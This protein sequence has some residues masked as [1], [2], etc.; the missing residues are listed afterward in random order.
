MPWFERPL[1]AVLR[2]EYAAAMRFAED[3]AAEV[4]PAAPAAP[5][6]LYVHVPFC[7]VLCP[8]C[9]FH[10]VRHNESKTKWYFDALRREI[11]LYH[12]AGFR[13]A[14]VYVGGGTPTVDAD[15]L[16]ETL[17][18]VRA[19]SPVRAISIETNPNHL[20]A[21][22]LQR[23]RAAGVT[24]LSV[25]VQSFDDGLLA[26]MVRLEKYGNAAQIRERLA[27][28]QGIFPTLN[29]D[30]I[31][32][33]P[34]QTMAMLDHDLAELQALAVDQVSFYPLMTAPSA[35]HAMQKSMGLSDQGLR[36]AMYERI[37]NHLL[38]S[39]RPA[40]AWCFSRN[41]GMFDEYIIDQDDYVGVGSG[42]F[43]YV[44]GAMYSTTFSLKHYCRRVEGGR[45][46][47]TQRRKL[48]LKERMR[49]DFLVRLFGGQLRHDYVEKRYGRA[50]AVRM[51][52]ELAAMRLIGAT[53]HDADAIRLTP[54]GMY[55]WVL[56][57][58]EFFNSVNGVREQ[59]REHVRTELDAWNEE[60][61]VPVASIGRLPQ[62]AKS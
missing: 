37:L 30:M 34:G 8:F 4:M 38:P 50:F 10:R 42:A 2:H 43:S 16:I 55:C 31:F 14:D 9:S 5:C 57:M 46:G 40:S 56:M 36:H 6:Q 47:I 12:E 39:Y 15:E 25:G 49:Y 52:P 26:S 21:Q 51:A 48:G 7:E 22:T 28:A 24:R 1:L 29:V 33:L 35:R 17:E 11:R 61:S 32:N 58:A 19:S 18:L 44:G 41:E 60:A 53:R 13:F 62:G 59:M 20:Q 45:S 3:D 23:Y 27:A 54:L